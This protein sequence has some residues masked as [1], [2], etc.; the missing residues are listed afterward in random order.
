MLLLLLL[1][2]II[3]TSI[4]IIPTSMPTTTRYRP[5]AHRLALPLPPM[6][7]GQVAL[8]VV[9]LLALFLLHQ[10]KIPAPPREDA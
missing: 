4:I 2:I 6:V 10:A 8:V 9:L 1:R 5:L 7:Q 3:I